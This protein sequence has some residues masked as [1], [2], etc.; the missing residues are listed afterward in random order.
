MQIVGVTGFRGLW[1]FKWADPQKVE[2][3]NARQTETNDALLSWIPLEFQ[4]DR[5]SQRP[6]HYD[7]LERRDTTEQAVQNS[8][9]RQRRHNEASRGPTGIKWPQWEWFGVGEKSTTALA[10]RQSL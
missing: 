5:S 1:A 7:L 3:N 4:M 8:T 10:T 6:I 9:L 2:T